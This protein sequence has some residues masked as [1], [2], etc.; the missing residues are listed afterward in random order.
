MATTCSSI[1]SVLRDAET[2]GVIGSS[3]VGLYW[4]L[5]QKNLVMKNSLKSIKFLRLC[6]CFYATFVGNQESFANHDKEDMRSSTAILAV[7]PHNPTY[8][9]PLS[10]NGRP[11]RED[12]SSIDDTEIKFQLSFK[13]SLMDDLLLENDHLYFGYTQLAYWQAYNNDSSSPFRE[14]NYEPEIFW[15]LT[16]PTQRF[17]FSS[18]EIDVGVVHESNGRSQL[19]SRSWNRVYLRYLLVD[20]SWEL[21]AGSWEQKPGIEFQKMKSNPLRI[22]TAM[23]IPT[24]NA[25]WVTVNSFCATNVSAI[26]STSC[27]VISFM[28]NIKAR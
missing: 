16:R 12:E 26:R 7:Q 15:R 21:G 19:L 5:R 27:C 3:G 6:V 11:T 17:G 2:Q 28:R 20:D 18:Q 4:R 9:L 23:T 1:C 10:Y 14:T 24:S 8:L 22:Q 13:L 25:S